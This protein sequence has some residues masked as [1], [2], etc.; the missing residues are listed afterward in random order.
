MSISLDTT[1]W[2]NFI[3]MNGIG[4]FVLWWHR[5]WW[6][7]LSLD[8]DDLTWNYYYILSQ[9]ALIGVAFFLLWYNFFRKGVGP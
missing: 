3:G 9:F 7:D 6:L 4:L 1:D 5:L 8:D 2:I